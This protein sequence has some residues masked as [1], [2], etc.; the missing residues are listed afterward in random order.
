[1]NMVVRVS[2]LEEKES[3]ERE[4]R[5]REREEGIFDSGESGVGL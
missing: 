4:R 5:D 3:R 2:D 1:M